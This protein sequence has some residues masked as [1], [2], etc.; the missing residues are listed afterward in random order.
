MNSHDADKLDELG[1]EVNLQAMLIQAL[2]LGLEGAARELGQVHTTI[3]VQQQ[4]LDRMSEELIA[5]K[6]R[7]DYRQATERNGHAEN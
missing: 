3:A 5:V 4:L 7:L 2:E 1:R 6:R